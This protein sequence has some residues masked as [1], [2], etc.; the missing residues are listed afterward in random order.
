ME[1]DLLEVDIKHKSQN[2]SNLTST[3]EIKESHLEIL[4][5]EVEK[6]DFK[7]NQG[8]IFYSKVVLFL[9]VINNISNQWQRL[10][11]GSAFYFQ[12]P[13]KDDD[14]KYQ[15]KLSFNKPLT[16][17]KY[18][19]LAGPVFSVIFAT[20]VLLS[21][22]LSDRV[23]RRFLFGIAGVCWSLTTIGAAFSHSLA[24]FAF[25]RFML[26]VFEAL[27]VPAAYSLI[28]DFFPP[29]GRAMANAIL[30]LGVV[31]GG[32]LASI[33]TLMINKFGWRETYFIIGFI[34]ILLALL[35]LMFIRDPERG[36]FDP[37]V[38]EQSAKTAELLQ[39]PSQ[40]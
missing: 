19:L 10:L 27:A 15:L 33:A 20:L 23:S 9:L 2:T 29:S 35:A 40:T 28:P 18:G 12:S 36:R 1:T 32:G 21:G 24:A 25:Y 31:L 34:G 11:I 7:V 16:D 38:T 3:N 22:T 37:K 39:A 6:K 5:A 26:G 8:Q 4:R 17:A 14:A 13:G 30:S